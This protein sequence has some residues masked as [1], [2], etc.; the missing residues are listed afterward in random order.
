M[1]IIY[2]LFSTA[3]GKPRYVGQTTKAVGV[4]LEQHVRDAG[5]HAR[6]PLHR[7]IHASLEAGFEIQA[8]VLQLH[9]PPGDLNLF[10]RYWINQFPDLLNDRA[11]TPHIQV[12]TKVALAVERA[13]QGLLSPSQSGVSL[14]GC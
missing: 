9:V 7:W 11:G 4:R 3:D 6:T 13:L 12:P 2:C 1:S 10:E 8:H 5:R 14:A